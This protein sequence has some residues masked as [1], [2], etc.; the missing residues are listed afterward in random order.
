MQFF[1]YFDILLYVILDVVPN[2]IINEKNSS[3]VLPDSMSNMLDIISYGMYD[4]FLH[5]V[6]KYLIEFLM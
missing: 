2:G 6:M 5:F 4:S 1:I 3:D